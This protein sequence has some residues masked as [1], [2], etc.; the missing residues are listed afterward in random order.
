VWPGWAAY[1]PVPLQVNEYG[2]HA[3]ASSRTSRAHV[4][5]PAPASLAFQPRSMEVPSA[6]VVALRLASGSWASRVTVKVAVQL[7]PE[8]VV[9]AALDN[10][11][12]DERHR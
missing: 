9:Q 2:C 5:R 6:L 8:L 4:A 7:A 12:I 10:Q 1:A 3:P 11:Q